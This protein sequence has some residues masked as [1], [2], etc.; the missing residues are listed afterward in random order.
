MPFDC[1]PI[2]RSA[3]RVA[4]GRY[5]GASTSA[6]SCTFPQAVFAS[7]EEVRHAHELRLRL[8]EH[9]LRRPAPPNRPWSVG[10]D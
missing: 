7:K 8:R 2:P 4:V 1:F 3:I 5:E 9:F 10:A 6:A